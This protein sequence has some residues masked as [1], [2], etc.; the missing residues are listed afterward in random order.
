MGPN[1]YG[2]D[3]GGVPAHPARRWHPDDLARRAPAGPGSE[4]GVSGRRFVIAGVVGILAV[5][6]LVYLGFLAWRADYRARAE[7]GANRVAPLVD[8]LAEATPPDVDPAAWRTAVGDTHAMLVALAGSG[9]LDRPTLEVLRDEVATL[10]ARSTPATARGDLAGLWDD[11]ERKA[12]PTL[13]PDVTPAPPGSRHAARHPRPPRPDL[14][15]RKAAETA[16]AD[17]G[18]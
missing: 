14:L 12:G 4:G 16:P 8:P 3:Y 6:G 1:G 15:K 9:L 5:W 11:L 7:F 17:Q 2:N 13:S 10:V 18:R